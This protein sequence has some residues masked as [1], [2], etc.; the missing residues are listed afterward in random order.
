MATS[1]CQYGMGT[2]TR[3]V[4]TLKCNKLLIPVLGRSTETL[5]LMLMARLRVIIGKKLSLLLQ[6]NR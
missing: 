3:G 2:A 4:L 1:M 5:S 6:V